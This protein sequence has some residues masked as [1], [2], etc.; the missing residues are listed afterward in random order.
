[1]NIDCSKQFRTANKKFHHAPYLPKSIFCVISD[2]TGC[3]KTN[4]MLNFLL[5]NQVLNYSDVYV[6]SPTLYQPAYEYLKKYCNDTEN[7]IRDLYNK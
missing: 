1:M 7:Q 4:L 6:Y 5:N 3:G 2:A